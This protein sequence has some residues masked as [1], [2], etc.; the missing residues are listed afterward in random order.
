MAYEPRKDGAWRRTY[1]LGCLREPTVAEVEAWLA[2][3]GRVV[4]PSR[5]DILQDVLEDLVKLANNAERLSLERYFDAEER[6]LWEGMAQAYDLAIRLLRSALKASTPP[7]ELSTVAAKVVQA[8]PHASVASDREL[9]RRALMAL[10]PDPGQTDLPRWSLVGSALGHGS[11]VSAAICRA[12]DLDPDEL[13]SG[14]DTS[15]GEEER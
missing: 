9:L 5:S 14:A 12:L 11:G 2:Q 15:C 3:H 7:N 13:V 8:I 1:L 10:R 6:S 4:V